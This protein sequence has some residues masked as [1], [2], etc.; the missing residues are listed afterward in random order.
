MKFVFVLYI[1]LLVTGKT[2]F[3][4]ENFFQC[5]NTVEYYILLEDV[6]WYHEE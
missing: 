6:R 5:S 4:E 3:T 1:I 2:F